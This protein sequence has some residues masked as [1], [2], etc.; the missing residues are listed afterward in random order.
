MEEVA[1]MPHQP[2]T[3]WM[4]SDGT[5]LGYLNQCPDHWTQGRDLDDLKEHLLDLY[6]EFG[7]GDPPAFARWKTC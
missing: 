2:F 1:A 3:Y 5:F 7:K 6:Q 4:E